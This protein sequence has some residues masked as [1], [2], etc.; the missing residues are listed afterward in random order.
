MPGGRNSGAVYNLY[1]VSISVE[2]YLY[3]LVPW[4][5]GEGDVSSYRYNVCEHIL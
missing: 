5:L 3:G 1:K 4:R 2:L